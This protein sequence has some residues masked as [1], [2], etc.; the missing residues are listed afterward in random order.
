MRSLRLAESSGASLHS[1]WRSK[2]L[3]PDITVM[4]FLLVCSVLPFLLTAPD[5]NKL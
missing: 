4:C 3:S 2:H 1:G 5:E